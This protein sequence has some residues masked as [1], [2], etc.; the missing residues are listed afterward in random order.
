[1]VFRKIAKKII[2]K[3]PSLYSSVHTMNFERTHKQD[4]SKVSEKERKILLE[5]QKNGFAVLPEFFDTDFCNACITDI[6]WMFKN[7]KEFV[8][9]QSDLRVFG[10]EDLSENIEKF[11]NH[12]LFNTLA[13]T[14]NA[15]P[16]CNAF[17]LAGKIFYNGQEF[18]SGESW[19]RDSIFR[20]FKCIVYLNDVDEN[21]GPF[22]LVIN[23][24]MPKQIKQDE[25]S[26]EL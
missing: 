26:A 6:E 10:A 19:H 3:S 7:K 21:N 16:T 1:M 12:K 23:S 14:Y 20:Q 18:G 2:S 11:G 4:F 9:T 24:H 5:I 17:T 15:T 8:H 13:N 22:Q 25:K